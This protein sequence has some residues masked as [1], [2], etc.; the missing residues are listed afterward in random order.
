MSIRLNELLASSKNHVRLLTLLAVLLPFEYIPSY[1]IF[2]LRLRLSLLVGVAIIICACHMA[3]KRPKIIHFGLI[4]Y[5][6]VV[7]FSWVVIRSVFIDD[8]KQA[9]QVILPLVFYGLLAT[10]ISILMRRAYLKSVIAGLLVGTG[11][12]VGFGFYQFTA[13]WLGAP[14]WITGLRPQYSWQ[15]FGFPRLQ[16]TAL[17]PLYFSAY[18]L[19]PIAVISSLIIRTKEYRKLFFIGLLMLM[20]VADVL[21]LSRGGLAALIVQ[22]IVIGAFYIGRVNK[23]GLLYI[24]TGLAI[25]SMITLG[26]ISLTARQGQDSDVTYGQKGTATFVSHLKNFNFFA[27]SSNKSNDDSVGQRDRARTQARQTLADHP[28]ILLFGAGAGQYQGFNKKHYQNPDLGEPN[29]LVLEQ[30]VQFGLVGL[31]LLLSVGSALI[32]GLY[33]K[34]RVSSWLVSALAIALFAYFIAIFLQAQ[35][36]TGLALTHLWFA[37]GIAL[38]L[39]QYQPGKQKVNE[40][41]T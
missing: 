31:I 40:K 24:I 22:F 32:I 12:A 14:E 34:T 39:I 41:T 36:F 11:L 1:E 33:K 6:I 4:E 10:S 13:N 26:L 9:V 38:F 28:K 2:G 16:S 20:L 37:V 8:I 17:E 19:L 23:N 35:T 25:V 30:I 29:N 27:S 21:T 18:L 3:I 5:L 15:S 7:W